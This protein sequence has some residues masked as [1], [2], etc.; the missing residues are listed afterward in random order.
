MAV[1]PPATRFSKSLEPVEVL[2][3][4]NQQDL[5]FLTTIFI[6]F[7]GF[8]NF[9]SLDAKPLESVTAVKIVYFGK[10]VKICS[11]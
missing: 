6:V 2:G 9:D 8:C 11:I 4:D 5:D 3:N 7:D 10:I 1:D